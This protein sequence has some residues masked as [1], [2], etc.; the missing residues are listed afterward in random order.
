[1][2]QSTRP[3]DLSSGRCT[4]PPNRR[5]LRFKNGVIATEPPQGVELMNEVNKL[6]QVHIVYSSLSVEGNLLFFRIANVFFPSFSDKKAW[7]RL[8]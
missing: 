1:M 2:F 8:R 5:E 7:I 6:R 3:R 4:C